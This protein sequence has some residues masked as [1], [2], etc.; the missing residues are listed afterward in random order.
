[1]FADTSWQPADQVQAALKQV[2][3]RRILL[4][5]DWPL[6]NGR[7][8][9]NAIDILKRAATPAELERV[10]TYNPLVFLGEA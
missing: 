7:L 6:L 3:A 2:G 4:G 5:S 1:V 8:Q 9:T 10:G